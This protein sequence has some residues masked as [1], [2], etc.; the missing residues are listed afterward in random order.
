MNQFVVTCAQ[1][2]TAQPA[3][4]F[5]HES[6]ATLEW[7]CHVPEWQ[8]LDA[9]MRAVCYILGAVDF[10]FLCSMSAPHATLARALQTMMRQCHY[11]RWVT[12]PKKRCNSVA[13][14]PGCCILAPASFCVD[15]GCEC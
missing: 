1:P 13:L 10:D 6:M 7:L 11:M 5:D 4:L 8:T 9:S 2:N 3:M 12:M 14:G 15:T